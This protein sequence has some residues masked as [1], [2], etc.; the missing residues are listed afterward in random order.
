[1]R[2]KDNR[3]GREHTTTDV[4]AATEP[5][6]TEVK[7]K[8]AGVIT[9]DACP[10]LCRI[11]PEKTGACDRYGNV[12]GVLTR[13]DPLVVT[14]KIVDDEGKLVPFLEAADDWDGS[15]VSQAPTFV[16]G[17]GSTTTK[18]SVSS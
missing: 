5:D 13:M 10:V 17:I 15:V 16:T 3:H 12:E 18:M 4:W 11:R 6:K 7:D 1:M 14:Q 2:Q 8:N 9:C